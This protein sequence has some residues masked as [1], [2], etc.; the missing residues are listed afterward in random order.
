MIFARIRSTSWCC[1]SSPG[2]STCDA[3]T[4]CNYCQ[5]IKSAASFL[6]FYWP[7]DH[8]IDRDKS[9]SQ[10]I[11]QVF[12][13]VRIWNL[14]ITLH[15]ICQILANN[16]KTK[17]LQKYKYMESCV[18]FKTVAILFRYHLKNCLHGKNR[19]MPPNIDYMYSIIHLFFSGI[20]SLFLIVTKFFCIYKLRGWYIL[21]VFCQSRLS[22]IFLLP[23]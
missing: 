16:K 5:P 17:V 7:A 15:S 13:T 23:F 22:K 2:C 6:L 12:Q 4:S 1:W 20:S 21:M 11:S 18:K 14:Y 9:S 8:Q 3:I 10:C 19:N